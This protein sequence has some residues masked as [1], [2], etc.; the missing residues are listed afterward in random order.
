MKQLYWLGM[1]AAALMM[2]ACGGGNSGEGT[3]G[4]QVVNVYT[5]RHYDP[6]KELFARFTEETGIQV[7]VVSASADEL[8]NKLQQEGE[9]SPADVLITVD[10]GR[11]YK[12]KE[13]GLLQKL[14]TDTL[15]QRIP[16]KFTDPDGYWYGLTYRARVIAYSKD[17]VVA[18]SLKSYEGLT[19]P[20]WQGRILIRSSSNLYNQSLLASIIATQG[21][22][23]AA[24]WT[25]GI[26]ANFARLPKGNDRDQVKAIASGEGDIAIVN[27]YYIGKMLTSDN[28]EE[29]KAAEAVAI[30][31]PNQADRGTHINISGAA[32]TAHAP[33]KDNAIRFIEYLASKEAQAVFAE[34]NYEYPVNPAV[35]AAALLQGWG[36]FKTDSLDLNMLGKYNADAVRIFDESGWK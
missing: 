24:Q 10:A 28:P 19:D 22:E 23:A 15:S 33:N 1:A 26:V 13:M 6:D 2:T 4:D 31:F 21:E 32:V 7:N 34:A 12:A 11:L 3:A 20:Q 27:T 30:F 17:R 36:E 16:S 18:D 29:V 9:Q 14:S 5:H 35:P 8:I 25:S